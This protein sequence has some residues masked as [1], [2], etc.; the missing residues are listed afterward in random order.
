MTFS[1]NILNRAVK[2][3]DRRWSLQGFDNLSARVSALHVATTLGD[4]K[5]LMLLTHCDADRALN[6]HIAR[7]EFHLLQLLNRTHLPVAAPLHLDESHQPPF[8]ITTALPGKTR[9][10]TIDL[11]GF[12][13]KLA[14]TL[15]TIHAVNPRD[16]DLSFLPRQTDLIQA[17]LHAPAEADG[18]IRRALRSVYARI[19]INP[20]VLL[21]GDFWLGNLLWQ[22]ERLTGL[23]D[24]E[25]AMVGD[26]LADMGKSRLETLWA[27]GEE[28]MAI[29]TAQYLSRNR[30]LDARAL[31][32]WDLWGAS[33]L[34]HFASFATESQDIALMQKQFDR[35]VADAMRTL[36]ALEE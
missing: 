8:L 33:R 19:T 2:Q 28:A 27:L 16:N 21:H 23:I 25:D 10:E 22:G 11:P 26:P 15:S 30:G 20:P 34:T 7:T 32:F 31:P 29:Y 4:S 12:C 18:H 14:D 17:H 13:V 36:G 3:I 35:F 5:R 24:W 1:R 6:P 9:F